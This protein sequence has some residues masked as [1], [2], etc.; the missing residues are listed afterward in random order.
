MRVSHYESC[1]LMMFVTHKAIL[2]TALLW[3]MLISGCTVFTDLPAGTRNIV[4]G[5]PVVEQETVTSPAFV[6][7]APPPLD[8]HV[9]PGDVLY[10]VVQAQ[11]DLGSSVL[12]TSGNVRG[13]RIDGE[14]RIHLPLIGEINIGG[15]TISGVK[16]QLS[17]A[18]AAYIKNPWIVVEVSEF[19]SQPLYLMGQFRTAGTFYMDRPLTLLQGLSEGGGLLDTANLRSARLI[20]AKKTLPVDLLALFDGGDPAQNV[21]LQSGDTIYVPDDKNQ[22]VFV[23]GAVEKPGPVVMPNGS[24]TLGQALASSKFDDIRGHFGY[25]RI[26]RSLSPTRGELLVVDFEAILKGEALPFQLMKGDIVYVPRSRIGNWNEAISEILPSLQLVSSLL[27]PF[28]QITYL[29]NN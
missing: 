1:E 5:S 28:V 23:F 6:D 7:V 16:A 27:E 24:L 10:V 9:G 11:P 22:N 12:S 18:Y 25:V 14:G 20:R 8:Y 21:W 19:K 4:T 13:N 3:V 26:V 29:N 2:L 15:L 17:Q